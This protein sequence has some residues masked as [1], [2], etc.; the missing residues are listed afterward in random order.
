[1]TIQI[2]PSNFMNSNG[3]FTVIKLIFYIIS[4][5]S[6]VSKF[7]CMTV[8]VWQSEDNFWESVLSF[9]HIGFKDL[10][11]VIRLGGKCHVL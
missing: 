7:I 11:Q 10:T 6:Y 8:A 2:V 3:I 5:T 9:H 4:P 1:M